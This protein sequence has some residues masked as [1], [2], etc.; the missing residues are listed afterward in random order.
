[1]GKERNRKHN[2][3]VIGCY[4]VLCSCIYAASTS[5]ATVARFPYVFMGYYFISLVQH[6]SCCRW[7]ANQMPAFPVLVDDW[8]NIEKCSYMHVRF[9]YT[10]LVINIYCLLIELIKKKEETT[11]CE[12]FACFLIYFF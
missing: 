8:R 11:F 9:T 5:R 12:K 7:G 6:L 1:M 3:S 10:I 2:E 4:C